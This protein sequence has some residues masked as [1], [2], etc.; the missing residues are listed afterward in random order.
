MTSSPLNI[1]YMFAKEGEFMLHGEGVT[2]R[3]FPLASL[4]L[5]SVLTVSHRCK[6][7]RN[8]G[9]TCVLSCMTSHSGK[10]S[11]LV[12][13]PVFAF[14]T[15]YLIWSLLLK[16]WFLWAIDVNI[17]VDWLGQLHHCLVGTYALRGLYCYGWSE[18]WWILK[19][20]ESCG[21]E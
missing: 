11:A 16:R 14:M 9:S 7:I 13:R 12:N 2:G 8:W 19:S 10:F 15:L 6:Q 21:D 5:Y 3:I 1:F 4:R 18:I 20:G 17:D